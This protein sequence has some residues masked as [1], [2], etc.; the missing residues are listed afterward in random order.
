MAHNKEKMLSRKTVRY[1][2]SRLYFSFAYLAIT[3]Y[4]NCCL[5]QCLNKDLD[6]SDHINEL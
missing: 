4:Y 5:S 1:K 2:W 6:T 3:H